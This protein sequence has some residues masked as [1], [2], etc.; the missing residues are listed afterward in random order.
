LE[1]LV[2]SGGT[3]REKGRGLWRKS[4]RDTWILRLVALLISVLLW[5]TALG[6]KRVE[7][8]KTVSLDYQ[9]PKNFVI[10]N[11]FPQNVIFR[12]IGPR[13]F[14]KEF[15]DK[16][17]SIPI[18]LKTG[19]AGDYDVVIREDML[20]V[21]LGLKVLSVTPQTIPVKIDRAV[22]KRVPIR[23][24]FVGQL[25]QG[26]KV[27]KVTL[28]PSTIE[29]RGAQSRLQSLDAIPTDPITLSPN[30]LRQ[31]FDTTICLTE[32]PGTEVEEQDRIV[33]VLAELEGSLSRRWLTGIPVK[34]L[35]HNGNKLDASAQRH[36]GIQVRP[37]TMRFL[38]EGPDSLVNRVTA[39]EVEVWAEIAELKEGHYQARIDW[40]LAPELRVVRRSSDWVDVDVPPQR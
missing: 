12:V 23:A 36:L 28:K 37:N 5:I 16:A 40:R 1:V 35:L 13:A 39:K 3:I 21:P 20:D 33:H 18:D 6:G 4:Q 19:K 29:V 8:T 27:T 30:S 2:V 9:L 34:I 10:A 7:I 32:L 15:E 17:L 31:E 25:P 14:L 11:K 26:M 38:L 22:S 24:A